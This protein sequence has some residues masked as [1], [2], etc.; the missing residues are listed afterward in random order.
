MDLQGKRVL[1]L[2]GSL[3]MG[4]PTIEVYLQRALSLRP[5][6][7]SQQPSRVAATR[8]ASCGRWSCCHSRR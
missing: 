8:T 2:G 4:P 5:H 7:V 3:F 1:V 6:P